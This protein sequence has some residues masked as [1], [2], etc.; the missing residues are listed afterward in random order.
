MCAAPSSRSKARGGATR[1]GPRQ[2]EAVLS[3]E[4]QGNAAAKE[5]GQ[6]GKKSACCVFCLSVCVSM[7]LKVSPGAGA[8]VRYR[9][10]GLPLP[11]WRV[12][13]HP[14]LP[15]LPGLKRFSRG[16]EPPRSPMELR[17]GVP[18][19]AGDRGGAGRRAG[20][21]GC[22]PNYRAPSQPKHPTAT[23]A[24]H[25]AGCAARSPCTPTHPNKHSPSHTSQGQGVAILLIL[26]IVHQRP[27]QAG[28]RGDA[29]QHHAP[30]T[31]RRRLL[32]V[33]SRA[34]EAGTVGGMR[35]TGWGRHSGHT[36]ARRMQNL[37]AAE[38]HH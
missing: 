27:Q 28:Q 9:S 11:P 25:P 26:S 14:P 4:G 7:Q 2:L 30:A 10:G 36:R 34:A 12:A 22:E 31:R 16:G 15:L 3:R 32:L 20:Q 17:L 23:N 29:L 13:P 19:A 35:G 37:K 6:E 5:A 24:L 1:A 8:V 38:L 33:C 21:Q 18:A